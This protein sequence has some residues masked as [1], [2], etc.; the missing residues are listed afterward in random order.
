MLLVVS[1]LRVVGLAWVNKGEERTTGPLSHGDNMWP[2][3]LRCWSSSVGRKWCAGSWRTCE[4][5]NER[6]GSDK[7]QEMAEPAEAGL[8][9]F[10]SGDGER[11]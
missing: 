7:V 6:T 5:T 3:W 1:N 11:V 9:R 4:G 8:T 10:M 2:R